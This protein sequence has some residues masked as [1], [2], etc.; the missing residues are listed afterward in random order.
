MVR[1]AAK[2]VAGERPG[3]LRWH[4]GLVAAGLTLLLAVLMFAWAPRRAQAPETPTVATPLPT[5]TPAPTPTPPPPHSQRLDELV[6][7][8]PREAS[9]AAAA[10]RVQSAWGR[11]VLSRAPLRSQLEQLRAFDLPA[12][13]ELAHPSRRDTC[14]AALLRLDERSAVVAVGNEPE[15]EVPLAQLDGL[16]T[17]DAFVWWPE[18]P[19]LR[20]N[21]DERDARARQ[22]LVGLG[23][24]EPEFARAV[25]RFQRETSLVADGQ[26]GPRTRMAVY[27]LSPGARPRLSRGVDQ[28]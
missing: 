16:W 18:D 24:A 26:L 19:A 17:R 25:E 10:A 22:A 1:Q 2:E 4:H 20:G 9:F 3:G 21:L 15:I 13:L 28:P 14:F 27:A 6:S 5:P 11:A 7:A 8:T 23:F 12:V